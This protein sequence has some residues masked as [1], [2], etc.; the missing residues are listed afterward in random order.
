M[1]MFCSSCGGAIKPNLTYCNHCGDRLNKTAR[2]NQIKESEMDSDSLVWAIVA[3]FLG[4]L[5]ITIGLLAVMRKVAFFNIGLMIFFTLLCFL[6][7]CLIE[8]VF[9]WL[10]ISRRYPKETMEPM[11]ALDSA[12]RALGDTE[13]KGLPEPL[14]SVTD[15]T[16]RSFDPVYV[17]RSTPNR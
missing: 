3:V 11:R 8:V 15:Q 12:T 2:E 9:I 6:L 16:T 10:L 1:L 4:G 13:M 14:T 5:G 17:E 7:M